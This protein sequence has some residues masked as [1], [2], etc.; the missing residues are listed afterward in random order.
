MAST[1]PKVDENGDALPNFSP[2]TKTGHVPITMPNFQ[3]AE[4]CLKGM[5]PL[6]IHKFSHK[7]LMQMMQDQQEGKSK[8]KKKA[9]AARDF[10]DDFFQARHISHE[11]WDGIVASGFRNALIES[12][13]L[14]GLFSIASRQSA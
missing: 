14:C 13:K 3:T 8:V 10:A 6:V 7:T 5:S 9:H 12:C 2:Y 4:F 1:K 11:G